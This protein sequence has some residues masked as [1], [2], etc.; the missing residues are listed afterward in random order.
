MSANLSVSE[1][2]ANLEA[3]ME[4]YRK[5][6]AFHGEQEKF[7]R[8]QREAHAAELENVRRHYE[9]FRDVAGTAAEVAARQAASLPEEPES[10]AEALPSGKRVM[11]S[12]L[13]ARLA[14]ERPAG[15]P[16]SASQLV[17]EVNRRFGKALNEPANIRLAAAALR[18]LVANGVLKIV[19]PGL[20]HHE[21]LYAR[22]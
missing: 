21:A 22:I 9:A 8:E 13:V 1:V 7:H 6:E 4:L 15:E 5:Q 10:E 20:P 3:Q 11:P 17:D 14:A 2:L 16:F 19:Q 18:R 12:R